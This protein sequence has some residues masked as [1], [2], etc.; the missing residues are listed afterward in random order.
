M[1]VARFLNV[2]MCVHHAKLIVLHYISFL[3]RGYIMKNCYKRYKSNKIRLE[4]IQL[5]EMRSLVIILEGAGMPRSRH[6]LTWIFSFQGP[7]TQTWKGRVVWKMQGQGAGNGLLT[8]T[9]LDSP[10][11][12]CLLMMGGT[13]LDV[14]L[15]G[16]S[17]ELQLWNTYKKCVIL[18]K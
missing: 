17:V 14:G 7:T 13:K 6:V 9:F 15:N 8:S 10:P 12:L 3:I 18:E 11:T 16:K 1:Y 2:C 5:Q 4:S